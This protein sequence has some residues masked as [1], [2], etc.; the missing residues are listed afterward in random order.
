MKTYESMKLQKATIED[1]YEISLASARAKEKE[2]YIYE[3][4]DLSKLLGFDKAEELRKEFLK[5]K[6]VVK[7]IT[8]ISELPSF[9]ENDEFVNTCMSFRY[10]PKDNF[11]IENETLIFDNKV[12]I[13]RTKPSIE[14]VVIEDKK[15][16]KNQK[17]LFLNLWEQ[18]QSPALGFDYKPNHSYFRNLDYK[19]GGKH[20]IVYPDK[21]AVNSFK[22]F[23]YD[24][25]GKYL[26]G[27]IKK[28]EEYFKEAGYLI[29]FIWSFDGKKMV[30]IWKFNS[31][32]VD[33]RSGPLGEAK[34]FKE[35]K[36]CSDLGLA[37]GSTLMILGYEEK[38][39]RQSADIDAY[40]QGP[41][42]ELP[43]EIINRQDF[44][45]VMDKSK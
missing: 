22:G 13:Y 30:D 39:R 11:S 7:Q 33:D 25:L 12:V 21:D 18:G 40:F 41:P 37:S 31:N 5:N 17:Q 28:N 43:L 1:I 4:S 36:E 2:I 9:S 32:F 15:F 26:E 20:V 45:K 24:S 19:I 27:I 35:G 23:D 3:K 16:A 6:I 10:I 42:P 34:I 29:I 44:F 8:N 14:M 38:L